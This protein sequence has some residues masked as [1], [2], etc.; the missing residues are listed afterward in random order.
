MYWY[1]T[2]LGDLGLRAEAG[3]P[4]TRFLSEFSR[5]VSRACPPRVI[6][7]ERVEVLHQS[8]VFAVGQA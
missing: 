6:G 1:L 2:A 5:R 3:R 4:G 8:R 7:G